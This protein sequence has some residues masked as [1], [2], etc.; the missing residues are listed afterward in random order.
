MPSQKHEYMSFSNGDRE[1]LGTVI[2]GYEDQGWQL[3][4]ITEA[5]AWYGEGGPPPKDASH[6][7][8]AWMRRP[9]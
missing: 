1:E 5:W 7:Y 9:R 3:F 8:T 6:I 4:T 2:E